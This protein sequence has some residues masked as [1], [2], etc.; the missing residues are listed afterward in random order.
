M[1][2]RIET[3]RQEGADLVLSLISKLEGTLRWTTPATSLIHITNFTYRPEAGQGIRLV[4]DT[5]H[6]EP[7]A[8][9]A[10]SHTYQRDYHTTFRETFPLD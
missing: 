8:G 3:I 4:G 10:L 6:I 2:G 5:L 9:G 7:A 1:R